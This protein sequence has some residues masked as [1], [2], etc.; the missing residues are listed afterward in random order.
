MDKI[1]K[2][3]KMNTG[4]KNDIEKNLWVDGPQREVILRKNA[5]EELMDWCSLS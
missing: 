3:E 1:F 4:I 2:S 5:L